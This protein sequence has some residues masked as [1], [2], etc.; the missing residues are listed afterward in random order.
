MDSTPLR[1]YLIRH[2][3]TAWSISGQHTGR[4]DVALTANGEDQARTLERLLRVIRFDQVFTSPAR[5]AQ[6]TCALAG[7]G[8]LAEVEPDLAEWDYGEYEGRTSA[9]S[10]RTVRV[11]M[12]SG[13]AVRA[14]SRCR[15]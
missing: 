1:L 4:T 8:G 7:L 14:A 11:G 10:A 9:T 5:R 2:G 12:S 15:P 3:E 6:S 13:T